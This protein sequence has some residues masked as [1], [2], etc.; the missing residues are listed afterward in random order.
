MKTQ[1]ILGWPYS[2]LETGE[3]IPKAPWLVRWGYH[4][5][6]GMLF[7]RVPNRWTHETAG[8]RYRAWLCIIKWYGYWGY[9]HKN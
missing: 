4:H 7:H 9:S 2:E 3:R 5:F 6:W 8:W 1:R